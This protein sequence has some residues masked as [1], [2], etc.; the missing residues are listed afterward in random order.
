M[1]KTAM[2]KKVLVVEDDDI[3]RSAYQTKLSMEGF[4]VSSAGNGL[5]G[6]MKAEQD[7]PDVILLDL[8]MPGMSGIEMLE[9]YDPKRKHPAVDVIVFSNLL[10]PGLAE[11]VAR[12]GASKFLTKATVTPREMVRLVREALDKADAKTAASDRAS[13]RATS[14]EAAWALALQAV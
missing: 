12:L 1:S 4:E 13:S 11:R 9:A 7:E 6:L 10:M 3:L 14:D 8:H 5:D 2:S